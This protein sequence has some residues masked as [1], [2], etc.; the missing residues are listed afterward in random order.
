[1]VIAPT[2]FRDEELLKPKAFFEAKGAVVEIASTTTGLA[3]GMQGADVKPVLTVEAADPY[4]YAAI[5]VVGGAGAPTYLWENGTLHALPRV[6]H[7]DGIPVAA[8]CLSEFSRAVVR[9][10]A[11]E[12]QRAARS[13][14]HPAPRR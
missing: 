4:R 14:S 13:R 7:A 2:D 12:H 10:I 11:S 8:I 9:E 1:M 6:A 5:V 3:R